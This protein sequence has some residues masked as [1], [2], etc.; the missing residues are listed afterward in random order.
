MTKSLLTWRWFF[1]FGSRV[2]G[3]RLGRIHYLIVFVSL[4][5]VTGTSLARWLPDHDVVEVRFL[6][7][8][9]FIHDLL[10]KE[11]IVVIDGVK[12]EESFVEQFK[13][14]MIRLGIFT[15]ASKE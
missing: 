2:D 6:T 3:K 8:E 15:S 14:Q 12:S 7:R 10:E 11:T 9:S 5:R 13:G 1:K 4:G